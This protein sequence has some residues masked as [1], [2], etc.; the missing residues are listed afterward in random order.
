MYGGAFN[1]ASVIGKYGNPYEDYI[2]A[3]GLTLPN[4]ALNLVPV[5]GNK[6]VSAPVPTGYGSSIPGSMS[7]T[8][9]V[10]C[11][12]CK[13]RK[14]ENRPA[15]QGQYASQTPVT[16]ETQ[17]R[18]QNQ[19]RTPNMTK[20]V[21]N[22]RI[23]QGQSRIVKSQLTEAEEEGFVDVLRTVAS[24]LPIGLGLIGGGPIGA[25]AGFA[26][27]A[28]SRITAESMAA[29]G[30]MDTPDMDEG[31]MERAILAEATL[32]ALQ[33]G[34]L[35]PD[36]EESIFSDMKDTVMKAL[37]VI[38][39][40]APHVMGAM[41][42]PALKIAFDSLHK[43]N[44]KMASGAESFEA[45]SS[46]PFRP[47]VLYTSAIDQPADHQ[48]EAFLGHLQASLQQNLQESAMDGDSEEE[49]FIDVI[50]AGARLAGKGVLAAAKHGLPILVDVL[51][52]TNGAEAFDDQPSSGQADRLLA[53]E[54][55]AQRALVA[56]AALQA[57]MK[58]P[59][60]QLQ[61]EGIF[62]FIGDAIK[63]IAPIAM[64]VAPAVAG[65][66]HPTIG[67]LVS[68]VLT[69]ESAF[70]GESTISGSTKPRLAAT[71][72]LSTKR[73]LY[74]LR[75]GSANGNE[76]RNRF[77]QPAANRSQY[78]PYARLGSQMTR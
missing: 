43:Y 22:G 39:K 37:P 60:Q 13:T 10:I 4:K 70:T 33:S 56:D 12:V 58:I 69:S 46:E 24:A 31:S 25:L 74:S 75:D 73:S 27:N 6:A 38:R 71:P 76:R 15:S 66:I 62:D 34:G 19:R 51:K 23:S 72:G 7:V 61:E 2:A 3:F 47:T 57:V 49:G 64:R 5:T 41:M 14:V 77:D 59:P 11:D 67:R 45:T 40:A 28:A 16:P 48:A 54:P 44:Q 30:T 26:L 50:K 17:P 32:S 68:T 36:L 35:R 52:R 42:E 18:S 1:S 78:G 55:L 53:A 63:T 29:D 21:Q 8:G 20:L 9:P 65:A